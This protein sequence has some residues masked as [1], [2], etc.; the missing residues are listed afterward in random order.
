MATFTNQTKNSSTAT[1]TSKS[2][3]FNPSYLTKQDGGR[4]LLQTGGN[5]I[6]SQ[7]GG[8]PDWSNTLKS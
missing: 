3:I 1:N 8:Y 7:S 5:I 2:V 6:L 4:L